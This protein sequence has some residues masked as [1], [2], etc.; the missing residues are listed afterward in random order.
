MID[1]VEEGV[2]FCCLGCDNR[3][4]FA[5]NF[6]WE[7]P[8]KKIASKNISFHKKSQQTQLLLNNITKWLKKRD[9]PRYKIP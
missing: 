6:D 4:G 9:W 7:F 1:K 3:D 5:L 2:F 8:K